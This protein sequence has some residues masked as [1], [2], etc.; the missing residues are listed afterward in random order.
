MAVQEKKIR[1]LYIY[2]I[3][4]E[5]TDEEHVLSAA[6]MQEM[7]ENLYGIRADRRNIYSDV[8]TLKTFGLDIVTVKGSDHG[9]YVAS[10]D[11]ELAELKIL[12][13]SIQ[14]SK[15]ITRKKTEQLIRKLKLLASRHQANVLQKQVTVTNRPKATNETILYNVDAIH[16]AIFENRQLAFQYAEWAMKK[17]LELRR[18]GALYRVSPWALIWDDEYYYLVA[19]DHKSGEERHYRVDK[20][21]NIDIL[22]EEREGKRLIADFDP[23]DFGKRTFGMFTGRTENVTLEGRRY[24]AGVIL[25][26]FGQDVMLIPTDEDHFRVTLEITTSPQF[27]GWA[28]ALGEDIRI[29]RPAHIRDAYTE[30]LSGIL[31]VYDRSPEK[32]AYDQP[33]REDEDDQL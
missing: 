22:G 5:E 11:F 16:T 29:V 20:M 17:T 6:D 7:L 1:L 33:G 10:R 28:A 12:V 30:Y 31:K 26:R 8:D 13:D 24:L 32:A 23:A 25:D 9:Y 15:F 21:R 19:Y 2:R 18:N 3:L 14:A 27:Y 4:L